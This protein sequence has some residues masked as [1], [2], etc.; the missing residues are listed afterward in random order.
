MIKVG[1]TGNIDACLAIRRSVFIEEQAVAEEI[2]IDGLDGEAIH[3][4]LTVDGEPA[5]TARILVEGT[6]AKIGRVAVL[7]G[8]RGQGH[9]HRIMTAC[10]ETLRRRGGIREAKLGAQITA[11]GFYEGLGYAPYGEEFLDAGIP[12][13]MMKRP[14]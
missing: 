2:E 8:Y 10:H 4:L 5:G 3:I 6:M 11:L 7:S 9:G 1:V 12:H 14:L 13:R